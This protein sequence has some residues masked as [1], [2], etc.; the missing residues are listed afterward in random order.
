MRATRWKAKTAAL[1]LLAALGGCQATQDWRNEPDPIRGG[2]APIPSGSSLPYPGRP[3]TPGAGDPRA[4]EV[5]PLQVGRTST[6]TAALAVG[7]APIGDDRRVPAAPAVTIQAPLPL[8]Q[9]APVS[10]P[11]PIAPMSGFSVAPSQSAGGSSFEQIQ[12]ALQARG[13]AWQQLDMTG[14]P[15]EWHFSCAIPN[16]NDPY[17]RRNYETTMVG[18]GGLNAM[19]AVL[20]DITQGR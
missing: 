12:E 5:P 15:G 20:E 14:K 9:Q 16:L 2:G 1:C 8:G 4:G 19:R 7:A 10:P 6:S 11:N 17:T 3:S 18:P 13:V